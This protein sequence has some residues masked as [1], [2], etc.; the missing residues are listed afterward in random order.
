MKKRSIAV[1]FLLYA[2]T[3]TSSYQEHF[4]AALADVARKSA[5]QH[6]SLVITDAEHKK[7]KRLERSER[8]AKRHACRQRLYQDRQEKMLAHHR[9]VKANRTKA[10]FEE[11][12]RQLRQQKKEI[13]LRARS[14][15]E[16]QKHYTGHE[17]HIAQHKIN[18]HN[19]AREALKKPPF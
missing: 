6:H 1:L 11:E 8:I 18:I 13:R 16:Q 9:Q 17:Q 5:R 19:A 12:A 3:L 10:N 14:A 2:V 15:K 7:K 4:N